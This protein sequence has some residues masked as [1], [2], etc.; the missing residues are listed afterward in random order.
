MQAESAAPLLL[1]DRLRPAIARSRPNCRSQRHERTNAH[2]DGPADFFRTGS[3]G[4]GGRP[5]G[6]GR[7]PLARA[8]AARG[9]AQESRRGPE[10]SRRGPEEFRRGPEEFRRGPVTAERDSRGIELSPYL[11]VLFYRFES[12]STAS[13]VRGPSSTFSRT[14]PRCTRHL[15]ALPPF[16]NPRAASVALPLWCRFNTDFGHDGEIILALPIGLLAIP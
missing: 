5:A 2:F 8:Y 9:P 1:V 12:I 4:I 14:E 16:R 6:R 10:E 3:G 13:G 15:A 7:V 11:R